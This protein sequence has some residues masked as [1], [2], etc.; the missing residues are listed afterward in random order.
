MYITLVVV[1]TWLDVRDILLETVTLPIFLSKFWMRFSRLN[2]IWSY[3]RNGWSDWCESKRKWID[4]ILGICDLDLWPHWWPWPRMSQGQISKELHL[5]N[6][7]SDWCEM[8][9]N[10]LIGYWANCMTLPF[11][12]TRDLDFG[13]SRSES[14]MALS[15]EWGS[16]LTWNDKDVSHP[17]MAMILTGVI[18]VGWADVPDSGR[19]D[20]RRRRAIYISNYRIVCRL[21]IL[22]KWCWARLL[23]NYSTEIA[24]QF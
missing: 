2:T 23:K 9:R 1:I 5:K 18:I 22:V 15:Q 8:K 4:Y 7:W 12:H 10:E 14:E 20:F 17:C 19:D 13:V 11:D 21:K 6:C 16:R 24:T 3:L